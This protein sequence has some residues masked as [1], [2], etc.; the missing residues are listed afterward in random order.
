MGVYQKL[1]HKE[2]GEVVLK[3]IPYNH[4]IAWMQDKPEI[5]NGYF[6]AYGVHTKLN[7]PKLVKSPEDLY[8]YGY[9]NQDM[10]P[11]KVPGGLSKDTVKKY[12]DW[13]KTTSINKLLPPDISEDNIY[14]K[15][16]LKYP[17]AWN[18]I[19]CSFVRDLWESQTH[20]SRIVANLPKVEELSPDNQ[21]LVLF[22][23]TQRGTGHHCFDHNSLACKVGKRKNFIKDWI[24]WAKTTKERGASLFFSRHF[25]NQMYKSVILPYSYS[26]ARGNEKRNSIEAIKNRLMGIREEKKSNKIG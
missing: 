21:L 8:V 2:T 1:V 3:H 20:V 10:D 4:C 14:F 17:Y 19:A 11:T 16:D 6:I 13:L 12:L 26:D 23:F 15:L 25:N 24:K 7:K 9:A 18:Q 22:A 5:I